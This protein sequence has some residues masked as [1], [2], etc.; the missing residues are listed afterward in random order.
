MQERC[1]LNVSDSKPYGDTV[2]TKSRNV[3][4]QQNKIELKVVQMSDEMPTLPPS[5][6]RL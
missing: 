2:A 5:P 1:T 4:S 6:S 3:G